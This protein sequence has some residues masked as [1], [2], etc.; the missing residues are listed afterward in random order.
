MA[1]VSVIMITGNVV[2]H[3]P[4]AAIFERVLESAAWADELVIVDSGSA[5]GTCEI[6][7]RFTD[8]IYVHPFAGSF[9]RQKQL[10]LEYARGNWVLSLDAD[11][12]APAELAEEIRTAVA[13]PACD[14]YR[15]QR[16]HWFVGRRLEHAG[17][18]APLRLWRRGVGQ[19]AAPDLHEHYEVPGAVGRLQGALE[20]HS[21]P[22]LTARVE[23]TL[24]FSQVGAALLPLP[25]GPDYTRRQAWSRLVQPPLR[26]FYGVYWVE[27]GY[28]DGVRGLIWAGMCAIAEFYDGILLWERAYFS[29]SGRRSVELPVR[30]RLIAADRPNPQALAGRNSRAS[31]AA[32]SPDLS[33]Y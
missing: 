11:E 13:A 28:K 25:D 3:S 14:G 30:E 7:A 17:E 32:A 19:W 21:T 2:A 33:A 10:A 4:G 29:A 23:K 12:V 24:Q 6:A 9:K 26:R 5:D 20:H 1:T 15:I 8:R 18:D 27:R 22:T 31:E 16:Q